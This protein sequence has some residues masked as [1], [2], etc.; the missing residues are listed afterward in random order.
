MRKL[1]TG[2]SP[3]GAWPRIR[4][5]VWVLLAAA[6]LST[7]AGARVA[8]AGAGGFCAFTSAPSPRQD[9]PFLP[10]C[11]H[12]RLR[13]R[14]PSGS[15]A[16]VR[17]RRPH[18]WCAKAVAQHSAV[19]AAACP[20]R[21]ASPLHLQA[22]SASPCARASPWSTPAHAEVLRSMACTPNFSGP[23]RASAPR[24]ADAYLAPLPR[25]GAAAPGQRLGRGRL[26][27]QWPCPGAPP[28]PG[29]CARG[30]PL[31]GP[32]DAHKRALQPPPAGATGALLTPT[33]HT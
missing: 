26:V 3:S 31:H 27:S 15:P 5:A 2:R 24:A 17:Q 11:S 29:L 8:G 13:Q 10:P 23:P 6:Q 20:P 18:L 33:P 21:Q 16:R 25:R 1:V 28:P 9:P 32:A 7:T 12:A 14:M 19:G 30:V 22:P 4:T